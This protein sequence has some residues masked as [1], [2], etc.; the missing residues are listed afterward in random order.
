MKEFNAF[1][2]E[3][4]ENV[5]KKYR[6]SARGTPCDD[7]YAL[8]KIQRIALEHVANRHRTHRRAG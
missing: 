3:F 6:G 2:R 5:R 4:T 8:G 1:I 7:L